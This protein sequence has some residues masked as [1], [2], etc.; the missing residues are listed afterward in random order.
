MKERLKNIR[1][2]VSLVAV[3]CIILGVIMFIWPVA[4]SAFFI[5]LLGVIL[6]IG[7][8]VLIISYLA[9]ERILWK[10]IIG[11]IILGLGIWVV[12]SPIS[13]IIMIST[14]FGIVLLIHGIQDLTLAMELKKRGYQNGTVSFLLAVITI[15]LAIILLLNSVFTWKIGVRIAAVCL[16]YD[17]ISDLFFT[18]NLGRSHRFGNSGDP[19]DV[20]YKE[21]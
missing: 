12:N 18:A 13:I 21:K 15:V 19:I 10:L 2:D 1:A 20:E 4:S 14:V 17:G 11:V 8:A 9:S 6:I 7:G 3:V 16:I 5:K